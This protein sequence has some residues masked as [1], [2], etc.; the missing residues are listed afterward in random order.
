MKARC[1]IGYGQGN[2]AVDDLLTLSTGGIDRLASRIRLLGVE[3]DV[4]RWY[5][6]QEIYDEVRATPPDI[7]II[8]GGTSLAANETPLNASYV[9]PRKV[10][11]I[12]GIQPSLLGRKNPIPANVLRARCFV[13]PLWA[14]TSLWWFLGAYSWQL[15]VGNKITK[16]KVDKTFA[17]HPG[18]NDETVQS[19]IVADIEEVLKEGAS[20]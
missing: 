3:V 15:A 8:I 11:Y 10:D 20:R 2:E 6:A 13:T 5:D 1:W 12:F 18:S 9:Y 4:Q 14:P 16:L 7:K 19:A 17:S